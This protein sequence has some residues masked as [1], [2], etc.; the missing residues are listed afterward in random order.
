MANKIRG[1][2]QPAGEMDERFDS[3]TGASDGSSMEVTELRRSSLQTKSKKPRRFGDPG[4]HSLLVKS[5]EE[6]SERGSTLKGGTTRIL[7]TFDTF[8]DTKRSTD[9]NATGAKRKTPSQTQV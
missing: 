8:K 2:N 4:Q 5:E 6:V 1:R 7:E 3:P 9:Q